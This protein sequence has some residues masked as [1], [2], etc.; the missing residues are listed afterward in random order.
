[1]TLIAGIDGCPAGW[2]CL[3][4]NLDTGTVS[5]ALYRSARELVYQTPS[6]ALMMIDIPIGLPEAGTRQCDNEARRLLGSRHMTIFPAPIRPAL[7]ARTREEAS[8][9]TFAIDGRRVA[10]QSWGLYS[11]VREIDE[12]LRND[13]SL[14]YQ[15]FE[16]HPELCFR[17]WN[18]GEV[19]QAGK[20][21]PTGRQARVELIG[22]ALFTAIRNRHP[23][24]SEVGSD[25][26]ADALAALWTAK[27]KWQ[28]TAISIP[29][30]P[31]QDAFG[32]TMSIW[33]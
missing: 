1:M 13:I 30:I 31:G 27:R 2:I 28:G 16:T 32:L 29:T 18:N 15:L 23:K 8:D 10:H 14:R 5:S 24:V 3:V 7:L 21:S 26:I 20:K 9:I 4:E 22:E 33:Y 25:D 6:P 11:K 12:L 17:Q 19:I